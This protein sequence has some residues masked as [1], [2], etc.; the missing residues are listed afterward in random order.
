MEALDAVEALRIEG[1]PETGPARAQA[2]LP[3]VEFGQRSPTFRSRA[4]ASA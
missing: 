1:A 3:F 4:A 2:L